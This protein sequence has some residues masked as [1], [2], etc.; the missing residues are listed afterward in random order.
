MGFL[1]VLVNHKP[2]K[3]YLYDFDGTKS[4]KNVAFLL[5]I[6]HNLP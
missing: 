4:V 5:M 2:Y 1:F 6:I 3:L